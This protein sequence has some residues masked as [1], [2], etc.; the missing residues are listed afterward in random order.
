ML[1]N[2]AWSYSKWAKSEPNRK[3][4]FKY[5]RS[6][7]V[8]HESLN[9]EFS[10]KGIDDNETV[11]GYF[12]T[13]VKPQKFV[14]GGLIIFW[15]MNTDDKKGYFIGV[16]GNAGIVNPMKEQEYHE[17]EEGKFWANIQG[18][19][20]L[21]CLFPC[22]VE[23]SSYKDNGKRMVP[24]INFTYSFDKS[25]ALRL[26]KQAKESRCNGQGDSASIAVLTAIEGYVEDKL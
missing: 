17:F 10:K 22:P 19:K 14:R 3:A 20:K 21:S 25:K 1:V 12:Q 18:D 16:Y 23:D 15:S 5:T 26:L 2:V 24:Q 6:G 9:F 8:P 4:N 7:F 11:Y 13:H